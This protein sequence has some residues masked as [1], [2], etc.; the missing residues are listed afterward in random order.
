MVGK[1][2]KHS[3]G[4]WWGIHALR[5]AHRLGHAL[6]S[7]EQAEGYGVTLSTAHKAVVK[8]LFQV[9]AGTRRLLVN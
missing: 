7:I 8:L 1:D 9:D 6:N 3:H 2:N 5:A 4:G